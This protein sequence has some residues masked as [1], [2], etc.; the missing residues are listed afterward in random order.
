M[1]TAIGD[2]GLRSVV[3]GERAEVGERATSE[4]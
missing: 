3:L 2:D 4:G 1:G